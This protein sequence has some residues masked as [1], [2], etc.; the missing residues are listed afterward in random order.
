MEEE[1]EKKN[2]GKQKGNVAHS[3]RTRM[4]THQPIDEIGNLIIKNDD[5]S[6]NKNQ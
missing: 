3:Y 6:N 2:H 5:R 1:E 4:Y